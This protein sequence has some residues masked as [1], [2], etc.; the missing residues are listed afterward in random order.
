MTERIVVV[1][2]G[3]AGLAAAAALAERADVRVIE[4]L[5]AAGGTWEFDHPMVKRLVGECVRRGVALECGYTA[6]RWKN[7]RL[8]APGQPRLR[9][10]QCSAAGQLVCSWPPSH[11]TCSKV[12]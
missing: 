1:G 9:S 12:E 2:G 8:L 4:R 5:P 10:F 3:I 6:L 7:R 11:I